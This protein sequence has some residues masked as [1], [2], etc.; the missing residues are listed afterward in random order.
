MLEGKNVIFLTKISSVTD[1]ITK[2]MTKD[3][4]IDFQKSASHFIG[5][6]PNKENSETLQDINSGWCSVANYDSFIDKQLRKYK[7]PFE[8]EA[9][10]Q[11]V[12]QLHANLDKM[13]DGL[14]MKMT[15]KSMLF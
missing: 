15:K 3:Y 1:E 2:R 4:S 14:V 6:L 11:K 8:G 5:K 12:R 10:N 7:I 9:F 13:D